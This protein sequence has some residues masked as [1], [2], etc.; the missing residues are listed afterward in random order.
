MADRMALYDELLTRSVHL[1]IDGNADLARLLSETA[2]CILLECEKA[3]AAAL[4]Q[5]CDARQR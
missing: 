3:G 4:R 1:K 5:A 2:R